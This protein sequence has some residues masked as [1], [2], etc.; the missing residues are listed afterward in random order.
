MIATLN[1]S[2][3]RRKSAAFDL[4]G[5]STA[6]RTVSFELLGRP[7]EV[8]ANANLSIYSAQTC[9]AACPFCVEELRPASRGTML[10]AQKKIES[11]DE[12]YFA[13]LERTFTALKPLNPTTSI[14]GGEASKDPRLPRII[15]TIDRFGMRKRTLTT[16]GSG[17]LDR[18]EGK[19][20]ID[21]LCEHRFDHLNISIAAPDAEANAKLMRL[22]EGLS[23]D[24]L[25]QVVDLATQAGIRV[26]FS[27]V[28]LNSSVATLG[29]VCDYLDF[30]AD[31]GVDNVIFRQLMKSDPATHAANSIVRFSE[32]E[33]VALEPLLDQIT[34]DPRFTLTRQIMGYY[35]Y[36]EVWRHGAMD[37]VFEEAD[38]AQLERVKRRDPGTIHELIFHPSATLNSTWQPWDGVLGP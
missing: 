20:I 9:N 15:R 26:R 19:R 25:R 22:R 18:R 14:T 13:N 1:E 17:L 10:T 5:N 11:D 32:E 21:W 38:L 6:G 31:L 4:A 29:D 33:R 3:R 23:H 24:Q 7:V 2:W 37:V 36:V 16:N 34:G 30:A 27:C 8:Y 28:L 12:R 35:Y